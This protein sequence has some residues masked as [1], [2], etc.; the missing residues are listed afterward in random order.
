ME[1]P[2]SRGV[3]VITY[4]LD[5]NIISEIHKPKPHGAVVAWFDSLRDEQVRLSAVTILELQE[6]VER[7]R[8]QDAAKAASIEAW[9]DELESSSIVLPMNGPSF[10]EVARMMVGR[11][12][13]LF[14]DVMIAA[15]ARIHDLSI[16]TRN[17]KDFRHL[18]VKIFNPFKFH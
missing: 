12:E 1:A 3:R 17:E 5:T 13:D 6:G 15:T 2:A 10:R 16:A 11:Q 9:V 4:L 18:G 8:R 14:Y 7:T